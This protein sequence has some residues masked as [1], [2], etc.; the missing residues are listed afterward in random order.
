MEAAQAEA[1]LRP[2]DVGAVVAHG[3]GTPVGDTAE[4]TALNRVFADKGADVVATSIKGNVGHTAGAAGVMGMMAGLNVFKSGALVP[5]ASTTDLDED[6]RFAVPL[7]RPGTVD[8]D[9]V[10]VNGFG[11]GGQDASIVLSRA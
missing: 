2:Q 3:T 4:I 11:F 7:G 8:T 5:T 9:A 6:I 10:Q 1:G